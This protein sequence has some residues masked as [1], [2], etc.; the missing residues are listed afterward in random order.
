M[1]FSHFSEKAFHI[2]KPLKH[3]IHITVMSQ[4]LIKIRRIDLYA[5]NEYTCASSQVL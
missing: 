2:N 4:S 3:G 5:Y 1:P